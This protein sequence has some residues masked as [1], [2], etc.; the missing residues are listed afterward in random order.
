MIDDHHIRLRAERSGNGTGRIYTLTITAMDAAGNTTT[1]T[2]TVSV[3]HDNRMAVTTTQGR[4]GREELINGL[5]VKAM[6]NPTSD[7]FT[8]I[9]QSSSFQTLGIQVTDN[10]GRVVERRTSVLPNGTIYLG[11]QYRP[12]MYFMEIVQGDKVQTLKLLK[13]TR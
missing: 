4:I 10:L 2:T 5:K 6:P 12:G 7:G 1:A 3:P 13:K 9:T 8:I 11:S